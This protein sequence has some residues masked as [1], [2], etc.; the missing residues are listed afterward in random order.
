MRFD[1]SYVL[2][3]A[4]AF[5]VSAAVSLV[6]VVIV[7]VGLPRDYFLDRPGRGLW[8]DQHPAVSASPCM[9]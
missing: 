9:C 8:V 4:A 1:W 6:L 2:W 7:V 3:G 5:V